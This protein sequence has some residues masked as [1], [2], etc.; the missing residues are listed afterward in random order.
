AVL[1]AAVFIAGDPKSMPT[2]KSGK[3]VAGV[4]AGVINAVIRHYTFY[5]EAIV[6]AFLIVNLLSPAIDRI[7]FSVRGHLLARQ[8]DR[9]GART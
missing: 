3:L 9:A 8:Q 2:S 7:V 1:F 4:L 6:Y 5:S